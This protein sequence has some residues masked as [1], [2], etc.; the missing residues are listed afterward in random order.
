MDFNIRDFKPPD[1]PAIIVVQHAAVPLHPWSLGEL[2]RDLE[3]LEEH[4]KYHLI[5]AESDGQVIGAANY[6]RNAGSYHPHRYQLEL[7]VGPEFQ[8]RGVGHA[9]YDAV[10][11]ALRPL[12]P[13]SL[14]AQVRENDPRSV[15]FAAHRAFEEVKRDFESI[16]ETGDFDGR[17]YDNLLS[18]LEADGIEMKTFRE[19]DTPEFRRAFHECFEVV[20]LDVPRAE[21]PTPLSFEFF[22]QNVIDDEEM[23]QDM[24]WFA[25]ERER[26]IGFTGG[27]SGAKPGWV[28]TWLTAVRREARGRGLAVALKVRA[29][30]AAKALGFSS[31]RTD[32]DTRNSAMLAVNEKLGFQR[33]PA[34]LSMKR[35]FRDE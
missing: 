8:S 13:I 31:I 20:R 1:L 14:S 18:R 22:N 21:P 19:L 7:F 3:R 33:Q 35:T 28:D 12:D 10:L 29:I 2:E 17:E 15:Q 27:Y 9:L 32:N 23:L 16:L 6:Y 25:L 24:F 34:V 26:I 4:L 30:R 5:V 11:E